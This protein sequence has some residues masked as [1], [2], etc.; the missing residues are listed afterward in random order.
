MHGWDSLLFTIQC[1]EDSELGSPFRIG[2][3]LWIY[4]IH[5]Y[6]YKYNIKIEAKQVGERDVHTHTTSWWFQ[7]L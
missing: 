3:S 1:T 4:D 5:I 2:Q 6:I 7:P